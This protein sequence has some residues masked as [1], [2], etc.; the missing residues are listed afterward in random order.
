MKNRSICLLALTT[1][2]GAQAHFNQ[3]PTPNDTL[4]SVRVLPD[5]T[6][7][8]SIYAPKATDV[9]VSGDFSGG[10]SE[11]K[12]MLKPNFYTYPT[13]LKQQAPCNH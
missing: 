5:K 10:L 8:L 11:H 7:Q 3:A 9:V 4:T 2:S 12:R 1:F 13:I 6:V